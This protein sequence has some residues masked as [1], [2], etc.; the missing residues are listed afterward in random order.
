MQEGQAS[1]LRRVGDELHHAEAG[2]HKRVSL[3]FRNCSGDADTPVA[4]RLSP[5]TTTTSAAKYAGPR[6]PALVLRNWKSETVELTTV[7]VSGST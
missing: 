5:L 2:E 7:N 4:P 6:L 1:I 3:G